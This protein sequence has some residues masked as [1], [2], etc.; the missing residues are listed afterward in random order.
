MLD[1]RVHDIGWKLRTG[2]AAICHETDNETGLLV[3]DAAG[4]AK[5]DAVRKQLSLT[6]DIYIHTIAADSP[7]IQTGLERGASLLAIN[8]VALKDI[9]WSPDKPWMRL[10][11]VEYLFRVAAQDR[12]PVALQLSSEAEL[13]VVPTVPACRTRFEVVYSGDDMGADGGRVRIGRGFPGFVYPDDELAAAMAHELAHNILRHPQWLNA[14]GRKRRDVRET[15]READRM[16][17]W[18]LANAGYDPQA[19]IRFMERWG[20]EHNGGLFRN[21]THDGWDE[22]IE[23]I[24]AE[25]PKIEAA[26]VASA[27][28]NWAEHFSPRPSEEPQ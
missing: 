19:A 4:Y 3:Q 21:R 28:L 24:R 23:S 16:M 5:P 15:E 9:D 2:N 25:V 18:L 17:P 13:V 20:P 6:G 12:K 14:N 8:G 26:R 22:R 10:Y 27:T 1:T 7:A 11:K